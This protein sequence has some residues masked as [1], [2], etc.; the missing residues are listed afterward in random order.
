V[1]KKTDQPTPAEVDE[2][3]HLQAW[4]ALNK[5]KIDRE[6]ELRKKFQEAH[7]DSEPEESYTVEGKEFTVIIGP[8][9]NKREIVDVRAIYKKL[10]FQFFDIVTIPLGK[11][12]SLLDESKQKGLV[13]WVR[14]GSRPIKTVPKHIED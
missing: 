3:G 10:K 5:S 8:K 6:G 2:L 7:E 9:G 14:S 11:L 12:D 1:K 4:L 13:Q